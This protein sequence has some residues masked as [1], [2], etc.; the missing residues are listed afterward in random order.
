MSIRYQQDTA[1]EAVSL[2]DE[3]DAL[4][5]ELGGE[6]LTLT[7]TRD[8]CFWAASDA[9]DEQI[10]LLDILVSHPRISG[11]LDYPDVDERRAMQLISWLAGE[12]HIKSRSAQTV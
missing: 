7:I 8:L 6:E 10:G 11:L 1:V 2:Q 4:T 9:T 5:S 12:G 3:I